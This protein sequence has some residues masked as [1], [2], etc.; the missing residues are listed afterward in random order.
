MTTRK[1][2]EQIAREANSTSTDLDPEKILELIDKRINGFG[3]E[4]FEDND[5]YYVSY[6]NMG[7]MYDNTIYFD[8]RDGEF[9]AGSWGD[10]VKSDEER[11]GS[12]EEIEE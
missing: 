12:G 5:G 3:V 2:L 9:H 7:D 8:S 10:L 4:S 6:V 11:F 1:E